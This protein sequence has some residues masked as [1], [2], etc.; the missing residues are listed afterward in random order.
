MRRDFVGWL[1]PIDRLYPPSRRMTLLSSLM[2]NGWLLAQT[3]SWNADKGER[4]NNYENSVGA[5]GT[6]GTDFRA[7]P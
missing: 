4:P 6:N 7:L 3:R 1:R 2:P 5:F